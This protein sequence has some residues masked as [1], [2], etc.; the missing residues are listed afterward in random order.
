[1]SDDRFDLS[2]LEA[3]LTGA[4]M[5]VRGKSCTCPWHEDSNPSASIIQADDGHWR[6]WCHRCDRGGDVMDIRTLSGVPLGQQLRA[7]ESTG[8]VKRTII[9]KSKAAVILSDKKAVAAHAASSGE[10]IAW[11]TY[12]EPPVLIKPRI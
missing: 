11:H 2:S 5:T 6:I 3:A 12:G 1:M 8:I 7:V 10:I 9:H 4:G